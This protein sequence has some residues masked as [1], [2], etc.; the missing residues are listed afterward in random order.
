MVQPDLAWF[1]LKMR[2]NEGVVGGGVVLN[3]GHLVGFGSRNC[4][5][6]GCVGDDA[7]F[8]RREGVVTSPPYSDVELQ[9]GDVW[10]GAEFPRVL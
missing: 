2:R 8:A 1:D 10:D 4:G 7:T 3:W 6:K 5:V 9:H